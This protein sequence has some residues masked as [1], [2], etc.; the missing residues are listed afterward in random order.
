MSELLLGLIT[1]IAFGALL[2]Q[3]RVLRFEKQIGAMLLKD[4]TIVKFMLSAIIVGTVGINL[5]VSAGLVDLKIKATYVGANLI[6]GLL[7]G[8]GWAVMGYCPG[9]SVGALGEG[10]WH[11]VWA[12]LGMLFGAAIYAEVHL[13]MKASVLNWG[14]FGKVTLPGILGVSPW[15]VIP[16]FV[17]LIFLVFVWFE[18]KKL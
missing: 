17:A 7:F 8:A 18:K 4:M 3:G 10:R 11:V 1:G 14:V 5:L 15:I 6:G 2:Q 13:A 16:I 9:T 12:I